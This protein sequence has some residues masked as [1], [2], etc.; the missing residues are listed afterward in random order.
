MKRIVGILALLCCSTAMNSQ[1]L[2]VDIKNQKVTLEEFL[3]C[4]TLMVDY[5]LVS[6]FGLPE[7]RV[8]KREVM[9]Y[10][11]ITHINEYGEEDW[12]GRLPRRWYKDKTVILF[13]TYEG[14]SRVLDR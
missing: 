4:D 7:R 2:I 8:K 9:T 6:D 10:F 12:L 1:T 11:D 3:E 14:G 13:S 5:N